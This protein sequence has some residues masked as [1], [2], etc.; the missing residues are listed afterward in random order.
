MCSTRYVPWISWFSVSAPNTCLLVWPR[1]DRPMNTFTKILSDSHRPCMDPDCLKLGT[2][3]RCLFQFQMH[4]LEL[5]LTKARWSPSDL[6]VKTDYLFSLRS[7]KRV[8]YCFRWLRPRRS[9]MQPTIFCLQSNHDI[10]PAQPMRSPLLQL[11]WRQK[12]A[13]WG[14]R[15][16]FKPSNQTVHNSGHP[17]LVSGLWYYSEKWLH[18]CCN[19]ESMKPTWLE[20]VGNII[21]VEG[22]GESAL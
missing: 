6:V 7:E 15:R 1:R 3:L 5:Q 21:Y 12:N 18:H 19:Q 11:T 14:S 20:G 9:W 4:H 16:F 17:T 22:Q 13:E 2:S 10:W 8:Q